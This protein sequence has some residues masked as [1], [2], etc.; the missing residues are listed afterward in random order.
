MSPFVFESSVY[1]ASP[2]CYLM[3][4][5][6]GQ[7]IYVGKAKSL[8]RRLSSYFQPN[9]NKRIQRMVARIATIEVILVRNEMESLVLENNLIKHYY[10]RY[11]RA[12]MGEDTYYPYIVLTGEKFP[13]LLP[14]RKQ[15]YNRQFEMSGDKAQ[16]QRLGP[17]LSQRMRDL[18]LEY[19]PDSFQLRTCHP[20][21]KKVCLRHDLSKCGGICEG[22]VSPEEYAAAVEQAVT[23]LAGRRSD[24]LQRMRAE[25]QAAAMDLFFEKAQRLRD[26]IAVLERNL[27]RQVVERDVPYDQDVLYIGEA[28]VLAMHCE[29]GALLTVELWPLDATQPD[30][31]AACL[32]AHYAANCPPE[33]LIQSPADPAASAVVLAAAL[34]AISGHPVR[35]NHPAEGAERELLTLAERNYAYRTGALSATGIE[36][37]DELPSTGEQG[38]PTCDS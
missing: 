13:R 5:A 31:L 1:P 15:R 36:Q 27:D 11:N 16:A 17:Y 38:D 10:P 19:V 26:Q 25:M 14:Y 7:V 23:F 35:V 18:L 2:G 30:P 20:L 9:Q 6:S 24:W 33:L 4:E 12:R 8:R 3:K 29:R 22:H 28:S 37:P 32:L 21:P 34:T